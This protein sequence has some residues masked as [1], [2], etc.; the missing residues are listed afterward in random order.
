MPKPLPDLAP[1]IPARQCCAP[2]GTTPLRPEEADDLAGRLRALADPHRLRLL[3]LL[4]ASET[5][6]LRT[7]DLVAPLG[8]AQPTVS[9]HLRQLVAAGVATAQRRGS[10]SWYAADRCALVDLGS[11]LQPD[12]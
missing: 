7:R 8:L 9:H 12:A 5:G 10:E 4:L 2:L 1:A 3:S 6:E 11:L